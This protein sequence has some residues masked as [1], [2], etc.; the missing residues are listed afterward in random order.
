MLKKKNLFNLVTDSCFQTNNNEQAKPTPFKYR[1]AENKFNFLL[2]SLREEAGNHNTTDT[3]RHLPEKDAKNVISSWK[4][5]KFIDKDN[6]K[7]YYVKVTG[8]FR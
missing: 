3:N 4:I 6:C 1:D 8:I 5:A 7:K 2:R